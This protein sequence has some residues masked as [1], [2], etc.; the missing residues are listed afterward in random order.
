ML[1]KPRNFAETDLLFPHFYAEGVRE[2]DFSY[3]REKGFKAIIFDIDG[4]LTPSFRGLNSSMRDFIKELKQAFGIVLLSNSNIPFFSYLAE[5]RI[6]KIAGA[7]GCP[8][9]GLSL[10]EHKPRQ[11]GFNRA[12]KELNPPNH[13]NVVVVGDQ[14]YTD[15]RGGNNC[16]L[17]TVLVE[18][19]TRIEPPWILL[20]RIR[21]R[22]IREV[23]KRFYDRV[24]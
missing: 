23:I 8:G 5:R 24:S 12:L 11:S 2:I 19:I 7:I 4:T 22:P 6:R 20:K 15:I 1:I 10:P 9:I 17:H 13:R 18:P 16:G 21:E 3:L 14:V